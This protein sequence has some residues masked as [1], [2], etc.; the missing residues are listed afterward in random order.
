MALRNVRKYGDDILRKKCRVV[1]KIDNRISILLDDM[2]ET[3][4]EN[5]GV[6]MTY[7]NQCCT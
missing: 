6:F 3:M 1:E 5:N 2:L 7:L 4:Y